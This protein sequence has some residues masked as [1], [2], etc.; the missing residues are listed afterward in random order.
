M[1]KS[2][3][4]WNYILFLQQVQSPVRCANVS[5]EAS[6]VNSLYLIKLLMLLIIITTKIV[7]TCMKKTSTSQ[8]RKIDSKTR[9]CPHKPSSLC[10]THFITHICV[11]I[12][13]KP[14]NTH[15]HTQQLTRAQRAALS[16]L[17]PSH[18][19][20]TGQRTVQLRSETTFCQRQKRSII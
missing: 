15:T 11:L 16:C 5:L 14:T 9:K 13:H 19:S 20:S 17:M 10:N 6:R 4:I 2:D 3:D 18:L 8:P 12:N 1:G 7:K